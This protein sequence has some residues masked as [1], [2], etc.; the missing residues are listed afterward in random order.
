[1]AVMTDSLVPALEDARE[2]HEA[3][4][5]RFRADVTITPPGP[6]RQMLERHVYCVQDSLQPIEHQVRELRSSGGLVADTVD[7]ARSIS[8][9]AMRTAMVPL[10]IG[11]TLVTDML[12]GRQPNDER[13]LLR[14]AEDEYA[15]TARALATCRAG[16]TIA[17][18]ARDQATADLLAALRRQDEELLE[19]LEDSI[20]DRARAVAAA[21]NG[22][23]QENGVGLAD[24]LAGALRTATDRVQ[25]AARIGGRRARGAAAG[26]VREMP[27]ATR[28]A[29]EVQGAV[30]REQ[31]LPI[32]RFSRLGVEEILQQLRPLSQWDLTVIEGYERTHSNRPPVLDSIEQLR[33]SE[34]WD[35]YDTMHP[36]KIT[37]QL[38]N[39]PA[40]VARQVLKYERL[41]RRRQEVVSAAE[42]RT[43]S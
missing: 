12:R 20:A 16:Q 27:D 1:M 32:P 8:R 7:M 15:V 33:G 4:V 13:R 14:N 40:G 9:S 43:A 21:A 26:A 18:E 23:V 3:V 24:A 36:D 25:D 42:A 2:A 6:Y 30:T 39:V 22:F 37:T 17:E 5:D 10:T 38:Q 41:H 19:Q 34:P 35:G 29:Q 28:M 11:S 31:E